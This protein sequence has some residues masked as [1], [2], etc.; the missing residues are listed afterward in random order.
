[1]NRT[2]ISIL[3][4]ITDDIQMYIYASWKESKLRMAET[5]AV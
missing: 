2:I 4:D 3:V 1:M 5:A